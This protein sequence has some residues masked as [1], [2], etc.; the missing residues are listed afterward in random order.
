MTSHLK[1]D[2]LTHTTFLAPACF[3]YFAYLGGEYL[4]QRGCHRLSCVDDVFLDEMEKDG[5]RN[6]PEG[7]RPLV[8]VFFENTAAGVTRWQV[9]HSRR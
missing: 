6:L 3:V 7:E 5:V 2:A 4:G 9:A 8:M 1:L